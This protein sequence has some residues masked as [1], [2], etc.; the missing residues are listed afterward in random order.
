MAEITRTIGLSLGADLCWPLCYEQIMST[1]DLSIPVGDDTVRLE[2]ERLACR[3][4]DLDQPWPTR[5]TP[6]HEDGAG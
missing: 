5:A 4:D 6:G 2:V 1:L 3:L